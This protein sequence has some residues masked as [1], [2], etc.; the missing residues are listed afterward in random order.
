MYYDPRFGRMVSE[1][2]P[3]NF[4]SY[5]ASAPLHSHWRQATCEEF[6]CDAFVHGSVVTADLSTD[7]GQRQYEYLKHDRTRRCSMQQVSQYIVK[8]VYGPGNDCFEPVRS[9]HRVPFGRPPFY[10]VAEGDFRG[11]P[12]GTPVRVHRCVE[13]WVDD[14]ANHTDKL[15]NLRQRG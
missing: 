3:E 1:K 10:L 15:A 8:F 13:D 7:L 14:W 12:R 2:G 6:E 9:T 11:N 5:S 4:K